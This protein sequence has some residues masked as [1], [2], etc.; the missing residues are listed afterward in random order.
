MS[1]D[2]VKEH[3]IK[4]L[5]G[6]NQDYKILKDFADEQGYE[7]GKWEFEYIDEDNSVRFLRPIG[8]NGKLNGF[9]HEDE[10]GKLVTDDISIINLKTEFGEGNYHVKKE[11]AREGFIERRQP[12]TYLD[13]EDLLDE[14]QVRSSESFQKMLDKLEERYSEMVR[15]K[16]SEIEHVTGSCQ[17]T[18]IIGNN[19]E[20]SVNLKLLATKRFEDEDANYESYV[21]VPADEGK[22]EAQVAKNGEDQFEILEFNHETEEVEV[23]YQD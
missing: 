10:N 15:D 18:E 21:K 23:K 11:G 16:L 8:E 1:K 9:V 2:F 5:A 22:V 12:I 6:R 3:G 13:V 20:T 17:V 14:D 7:L 4:S 19:S